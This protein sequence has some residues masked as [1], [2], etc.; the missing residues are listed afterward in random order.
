M[1]RSVH[2]KRGHRSSRYDERD[3]QT[4]GE[5]EDGDNVFVFHGATGPLALLSPRLIV[6]T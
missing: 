4:H 3:P 6:Y 5:Q 1:E 2:R